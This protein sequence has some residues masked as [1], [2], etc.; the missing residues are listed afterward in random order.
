MFPAAV[1]GETKQEKRQCLLRSRFFRWMVKKMV[2]LKRTMINLAFKNRHTVKA[3]KW[4]VNPPCDLPLISISC[5]GAVGMHEYQSICL[6]VGL[7]IHYS[8]TH[9]ECVSAAN[10]PAHPQFFPDFPSVKNWGCVLT[11]SSLYPW[12]NLLFMLL[13][14]NLMGLSVCLSFSSSHPYQGS[15]KMTFWG[16]VPVFPLS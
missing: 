10:T 9:C 13:S 1:A 15:T 6:S 2:F 12:L 3:V 4:L 7:C 8:C 16:I 14:P 5:R 11:C